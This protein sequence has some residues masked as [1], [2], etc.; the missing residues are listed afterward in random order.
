MEGRDILPGLC[1]GPAPDVL[2]PLA[3]MMEDLQWIAEL[4]T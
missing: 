2:P 1:E 4:V 3:D